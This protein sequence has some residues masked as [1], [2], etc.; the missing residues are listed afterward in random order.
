MKNKKEKYD[1]VII[2]AGPAGL[3]AAEVLAK[4]N[5]EVLVLEKNKIIGRK[6]CGGGLSRKFLEKNFPLKKV[7]DRFFNSVYYYYK[8]K[9]HKISAKNPLIVITEREKLGE[10]MVKEAIKK[11][12]KIKKETEVKVIGKNFLIITNNKKIYF[13]YL[14]GADG[15]NSIVRKF[16]KIP[17]EKFLFSLGYN[18]PKNYEN[19]EIFFDS[20]IFGDGYGAIFPH[21]EYTQVG[22]TIDSSLYSMKKAKEVLD[23]WIKKMNFNIEDGEF[24]AGIINYDYRGFQF[25]NKFLAGEAAGFTSGLM[26]EGIFQAII[27]GEEI[28]K[29]IINHKYNCPQIKYI[30][31]AKFLQEKIFKR[32]LKVKNRSLANIINFCFSISKKQNIYKML[33]KIFS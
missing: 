20:K 13:D 26:G 14:I 5:R 11:G 29:K 6:P 23:K 19:L 33:Y 28:A 3:K 9:K 18:I 8:K 31:R 22:I 27:S 15:A 21:K 4:N 17:S 25:K 1:I 16:L 7:G 12:A 10:Q 24:M 30:L 32:I 2:G